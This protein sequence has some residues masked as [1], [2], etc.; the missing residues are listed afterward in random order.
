MYAQDPWRV[1][2]KAMYARIITSLAPR[3]KDIEDAT[4][5]EKP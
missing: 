1:A 4:R 5:G 3:P 2:A